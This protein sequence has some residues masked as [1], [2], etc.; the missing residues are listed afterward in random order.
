MPNEYV[1][2]RSGENITTFLD[3][4]GAALPSGMVI[5][6]KFRFQR[7]QAGVEIL[8][9]FCE[10]AESGDPKYAANVSAVTGLM[11]HDV[12]P[13]SMHGILV[14]LKVIF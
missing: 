3:K 2:I 14:L 4:T 6:R 7:T 5:F 8:S 13:D 10:L 9:P 12:P 1:N 11:V